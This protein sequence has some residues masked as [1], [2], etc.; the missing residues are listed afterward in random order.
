MFRRNHK[1]VNIRIYG[2]AGHDADQD[3]EA[4]IARFGRVPGFSKW[5]S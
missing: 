1:D 5:R 3:L 4:F 2:D